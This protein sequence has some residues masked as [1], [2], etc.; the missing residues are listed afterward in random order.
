MSLII[1]IGSNIGDKEKNLFQVKKILRSK[2]TY[3]SESPIYESEPVDYINQD[4]FYN[5]LLEFKLPHLSPLQVLD[6]CQEIET[7]MGRVKLI[8]KGPRLID[9]DIIFWG[10]E[11]LKTKRLTIPHSSWSIR[12]FI[13]KPLKH[14]PYFKILKKSFKIPTSFHS[15]AKQIVQKKE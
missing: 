3:I 15:T 2:F 6:I 12:S 10:L 4:Y 11:S 1:A 7:D 14:L 5:Q 8:D 13:V 9:I